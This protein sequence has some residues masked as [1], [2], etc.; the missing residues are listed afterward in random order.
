LGTDTGITSVEASNAFS[1]T[2]GLCRRWIVCVLAN[3]VTSLGVEEG[4]TSG[5]LVH[6]VR[7]EA[8]VNVRIGG[9]S[10]TPPGRLADPGNVGFCISNIVRLGKN[11]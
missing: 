8:S 2:S 3:K 1:G 4:I 5:I 10:K 6:E 11:N 7:L 9:G